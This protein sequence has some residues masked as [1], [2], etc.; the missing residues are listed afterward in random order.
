[1]TGVGEIAGS[2]VDEIPRAR[3]GAKVA[4]AVTAIVA[5]VILQTSG[6]RR[7]V[8]G[9]VAAAQALRRPSHV[10]L[11]FGSDPEG[12]DV[13]RADG[14]RLGKTPLATDVLSADVPTVYVLHKSG[15][16]S[17]T[18]AVVPNLP[19]QVFTALP[20]EVAAAAAV[21]A[22]APPAVIAPASAAAPAAVMTRPVR[23][24][25]AR[26]PPPVVLTSTAP[27]TLRPE[28]MPIDE[29]GVLEPTIH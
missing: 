22:A 8:A 3:Y 28:P 24:A 7:P 15:Y 9:V 21:V 16:S 27:S 25:Q 1:V 11:S 10:R 20:R 5:V 2:R 4:L 14:V 26:R 19:T 18:V 23:R 17:K 13:I 29:D 6:L 12:A